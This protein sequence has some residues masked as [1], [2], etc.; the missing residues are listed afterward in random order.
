MKT[1]PNAP[2]SPIYSDMA[3]V[4]F[5]CQ[6]GY[7]GLTIRQHF[8]GLAMQGFRANPDYSQT[9]PDNIANLSVQSADALI[10]ALNKEV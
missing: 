4:G 8:A 7:N 5:Q 1:K 9:H 6:E 2:I 10:E 3:P